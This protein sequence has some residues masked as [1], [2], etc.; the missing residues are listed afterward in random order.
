MDDTTTTPATETP[1]ET[2]V[3]ETA[4]AAESTEAAA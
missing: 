1:V 4:P 3:E 2:P